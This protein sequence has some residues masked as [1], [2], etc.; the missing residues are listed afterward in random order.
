M[1]KFMNKLNKVFSLFFIL[2]FLCA[3]QFNTKMDVQTLSA[4]HLNRDKN[5]VLCTPIHTNPLLYTID[6]DCFENYHSIESSSRIKSDFYTAALIFILNLFLSEIFIFISN[7]SSIRH[8]NK[9]L[10]TVSLIE[11]LF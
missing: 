4:P 6:N 8:R 11:S 5:S 10:S 3:F 2:T 9:F 1:N 7:F